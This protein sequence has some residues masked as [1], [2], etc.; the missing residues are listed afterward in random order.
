MH[1]SLCCVCVCVCA[2]VYERVTW[3][4][5]PVNLTYWRSTST[6]H[7]LLLLLL[8]LRRSIP[9]P[10]YVCSPPLM[11]PS[12]PALDVVKPFLNCFCSLGT[13]F[14]S[15]ECSYVAQMWRI[16]GREEQKRLKLSCSAESWRVRCVCHELSGCWFST[17][18]HSRC[19]GANVKT[20]VRV[21]LFKH[22]PYV[23]IGG[24]ELACLNAPF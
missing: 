21:F 1:W 24:R 19:R 14:R 20:S 3:L 12:S 2:C 16:T 13:Y 23:E 22:N 10:L 4:L 17:I 18:T 8:L 7:F 5:L 11:S 15:V 9:P 6:Q